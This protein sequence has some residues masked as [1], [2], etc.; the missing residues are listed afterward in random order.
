MTPPRQRR[1]RPSYSAGVVV[2]ALTIIIA[3]WASMGWAISVLARNAQ[4]GVSVF[5][6]VQI[7]IVIYILSRPYTGRNRD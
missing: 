3:L 6:G 5:E 4:D 1:T 7:A 2:L